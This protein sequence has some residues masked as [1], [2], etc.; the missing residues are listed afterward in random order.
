MISPTNVWQP[1]KM[2]YK[3]MSYVLE[4]TLIINM[5][6]TSS[7][8]NMTLNLKMPIFKTDL[9]DFLQFSSYE[10]SCNATK[11]YSFC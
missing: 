10:I 3:G 7:F 9:K 8:K 4:K 5:T 6:H 2:N 11:T 1:Y